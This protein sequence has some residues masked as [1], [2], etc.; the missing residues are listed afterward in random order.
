MATAMTNRVNGTSQTSANGSGKQRPIW[1]KKGFPVQVAVF[2]FP[3]ENGP[4]NYSVKLTRSFR[5]DEE[6][7]WETTDYLSG[8]DLLRGVK[9][10]EA[11]DTFIQAR[12]EADYKARKAATAEAGEGIP[13]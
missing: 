6:S 8:S 5:R 4:P 1:T 2:E 3:S 10:L 12:L 11:A 9:L 7:E 13:F